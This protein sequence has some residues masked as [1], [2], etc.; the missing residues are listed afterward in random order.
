MEGIRNTS[1]GYQVQAAPFVAKTYE[2]VNDQR[3][4]CLIRW[5]KGNNSFVVVNPSDFSQ[6]LLPSYFKHSN[7][8]SFVRQLNT[9]GFRKVDPDRW[10]F[11]HHLFL[12]GQIHLLPHITRRSKKSHVGLGAGSSSSISGEEKGDVEGEVEKTLLQ[13]LY[14]LRQEQRAL[15]EE[16]QVMSRRL[17]AT[18]R[19]PHQMMS[20]LIK[21]AEDPESFS[22]LVI[23]KKQ[24]SAAAKK[25]R[26]VA[27]AAAV[28]PPAHSI[29]D[30]VFL[31]PSLLVPGTEQ[32]VIEP[33]GTGSDRMSIEEVKPFAFAPDVSAIHSY[34]AELGSLATAPEAS[35]IGPNHASG[36]SFLPDFALSTTSS[37]SE[38]AAAASFPF[39]LLGHGFC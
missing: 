15:D 35:I 21:M 8:S 37:S 32:T 22:G 6:F 34:G 29:N 12:R 30:G 26:L 13:E 28:A 33:L 9:Y 38:T 25:R 3:T 20:F 7:F 17:Q 31:L 14:R 36:I 19:R 11:A 18:E 23:S 27:A 1:V 16:L 39:S 2:M 24:Q 5:G 10:E 4:D